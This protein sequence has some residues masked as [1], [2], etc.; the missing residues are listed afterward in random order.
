MG[1]EAP[2]SGRGSPAL[3]RTLIPPPTQARE[4]CSFQGKESTQFVSGQETQ[5]CFPLPPPRIKQGQKCS[6]D[7]AT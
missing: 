4:S 3:S 5:K 6:S 1:A 7:A 2:F